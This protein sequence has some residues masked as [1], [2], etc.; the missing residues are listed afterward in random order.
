MVI[1]LEVG[2]L[3]SP[4]VQLSGIFENM[5]SINNSGTDNLAAFSTLATNVSIFSSDNDYIIIGKP[6]KFEEIEFILQ[7]TA[8][9]AGIAPTIE[10]STGVDTWT[11]FTP[12]DGTNG[13]RN[14][15]VM[16][17]LDG[18]I[19]TWSTGLNSEYLIKITRTRNSLTRTPIEGIV[20]VSSATEYFW[21]KDGNISAHDISVDNNLC[22]DS[23]CITNWSAV[24]IS[25]GNSTAEIIT[26]SNSTGL[27][28]N[29]SNLETDPIYSAWDKST[30]IS[31]TESQISDL[32]HT[33]DTNLDESEVDAFVANNGY[34]TSVT[35]GTAITSSGGTTPSISVTAASIGNTQLTFNTGQH[36]TT[37]SAVTFTTVNTGLGANE[38]YDMNQ[39]VQTTDSPTFVDLNSIRYVYGDFGTIARST[40]E[41]LRLND[42]N[43]HTSGIYSG[44]HLRVDGELRQGSSDYGAYE[45][46]ATGQAYISDYVVALGGVNIGGTADPVGGLFI[47][48]PIKSTST[49]D[50]YILTVDNN[51]DHGFFWDE[52]THELELHNNG[53]HS[54]R[55]DLDGEDFTVDDTIFVDTLDA[56]LIDLQSAQQKTISAGEITISTESFIDVDTESN[57]ASDYLHTINGAHG[58]G[59][60]L[61]MRPESDARTVIIDHAVGNILSG[62]DHTMDEIEDTFCAIYDSVAGGWIQIGGDLN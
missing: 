18:D 20:Q 54:F 40:D 31:I 42:G 30:G 36:L 49:S 34:V 6:E 47:N 5:T 22:I 61:C 60:I 21:N 48:A 37:T 15:G 32:S 23:N 19:P 26:A 13:L 17:W 14:N 53:V 29:W 3:V 12:T 2:A 62:A 51:A 9:G 44:T 25:G 57:A 28:I 33:V 59:H 43:T 38:L 56:D 8:S 58:S 39:N 55:F 16:L 7:Q 11:S 52:S 50:G 4:V 27:L 45:I 10:F 1:G 46:Q 24:N 41:W 35:G